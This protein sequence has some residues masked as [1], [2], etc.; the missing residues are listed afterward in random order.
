MTHDCVPKVAT[1]HIVKFADD[2]AV[3]GLIRGDN[4]LAC[5]EEVEQLVGWCTDN[6][7]QILNVDKTKEII[8]DFRNNQ[9]SHTPLLINNTDVEVVSSIKFLG[10][11][12]TDHLPWSV[13]T[14]SLVKRAQ[15]CL[16][17]LHRMRRAH[18]PPPILTTFYRSTIESIL[19]SCIC[20]WPLNG[21]M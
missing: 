17:F 3:V 7:N 2:I 11:H 14:V 5:R 1:N 15:Q 19:T 16:H 4:D 9:P 20:V 18:L 8:V 10:V 12:I 6:N 21:R 13:N